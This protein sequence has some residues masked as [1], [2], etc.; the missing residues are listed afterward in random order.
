V[1]AELAPVRLFLIDRRSD[2]DPDMTT[3]EV[4]AV[5]GT[6]TAAVAI[7]DSHTFAEAAVR[8]LAASQF[9]IKKISVVGRGYHS[10]EAVAGFYNTG[11][12]VKFWG[13]YGAFWGGLW[14]LFFGGLFLTVPFVSALEGVVVIGGLSAI[15]AA[16]YSIGIPKDTV[17]RYEKEITADRFLLIVHGTSSEVERARDILKRAGPTQIDVHQ[18][19]NMHQT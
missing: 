1:I 9:D 2:G 8:E 18:H 12:R 15:G 7:F 6:D 14:G 19:L 3:K 16:L 17:L 11:D 5:P 10:D 4:Q 13:K